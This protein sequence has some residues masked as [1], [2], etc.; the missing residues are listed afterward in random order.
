MA[1]LNAG[2]LLDSMTS[3]AKNSLSS[4][5]PGIK[6]LA[7]TSFKT[8]AQTLVD[9]ESMKLNGTVKPDQA[10]L[11]VEMQKNALKVVLLSEE[12]L[13]LLAVEAAINAA[14]S[15]IQGTV[16]MALGFSIL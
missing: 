4:N 7:T 13:G 9:I 1:T 11:L 3:A 8:L 12:G 15:V 10:K 2:D 5:W 16:N 6:D 14:L